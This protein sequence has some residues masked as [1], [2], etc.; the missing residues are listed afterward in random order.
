M[1]SNGFLKKLGVYWYYVKFYI[2][3]L[4]SELCILAEVFLNVLMYL[5]STIIHFEV[6]TQLYSASDTHRGV[7]SKSF[8]DLI[9]FSNLFKDFNRAGEL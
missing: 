9:F 5:K 2:Q 4:P 3:I 1:G 6:V 8:R 7:V